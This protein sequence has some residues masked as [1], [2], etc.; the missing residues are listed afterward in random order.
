MAPRDRCEV[1]VANLYS[2]RPAAQGLPFEPGGTIPRHLLDLASNL[3]DVGEVCGEGVFGAG[4]LRR[5]IRF[6]RPIVDAVG[7]LAQPLG[8]ASYSLAQHSGIDGSHL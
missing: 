1:V 8:M 4:G 3:A 7:K 6:D 5:L 2:D